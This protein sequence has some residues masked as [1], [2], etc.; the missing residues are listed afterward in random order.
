MKKTL[1]ILI[2]L[3]TAITAQAQEVELKTNPFGF[4]IGAYNVTAEFQLQDYPSTTVLASAWYNSPDFKDWMGTDRDGGLSVGIRKY[5]NRYEDK[6]VFLGVA[7]RYI[8]MTYKQNSTD[9][10]SLGFTVGYKYIYNEKITIDAFIGGGRIVW[11]EVR[12]SYW[13]PAEFIS[14]FNFG[15][16]F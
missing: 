3:L 12:D 7:S 5:H 1:A 14:G 11:E 6:G 4:I 16:R 13:A 2:V 10:L 8:P 9:I 15:Y